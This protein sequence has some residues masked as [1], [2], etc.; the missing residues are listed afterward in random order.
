MKKLNVD[1]TFNVP[2]NKLDD[3]FIIA[4]KRCGND[5]ELV[6]KVIERYRQISGR[7]IGK[8]VIIEINEVPTVIQFDGGF[9]SDTSPEGIASMIQKELSKI[10]RGRAGL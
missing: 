10:Y 9:I 7:F 8:D 2:R 5:F 6:K 3:E 1:I 4:L